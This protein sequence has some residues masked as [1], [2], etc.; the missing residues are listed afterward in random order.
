MYSRRDA[1]GGSRR[2]SCSDCAVYVSYQV[3]LLAATA[4][5]ESLEVTGIAL[6]IDGWAETL[7]SRNG[8]TITHE[9][10]RLKSARMGIIV[11]C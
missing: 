6:S 8:T 9:A 2:F 3:S 10:V 7:G 11:I 5:M 1:C 4:R